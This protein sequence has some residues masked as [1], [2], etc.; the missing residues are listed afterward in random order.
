MQGMGVLVTMAQTLLVKA[1]AASEQGKVLLDVLQKLTKAIPAGTVSPAVQ[2]NVIDQTKMQN[3]QN[4]AIQ[5]QLRQRAMAQG[6]GGAPG[7]APAGG[8]PSMGAAA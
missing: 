1:G 4:L 6:A 5:Q 7:G 2:N 3:T 8:P